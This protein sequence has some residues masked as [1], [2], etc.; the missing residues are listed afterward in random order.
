MYTARPN[1][2][3]IAWGLEI[4]CAM[5]F[6]GEHSLDSFLKIVVID[7]SHAREYLEEKLTGKR[8]SKDT[9]FLSLS[10]SLFLSL[11]LSL[12]LKTRTR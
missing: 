7:P 6:P 11:S 4:V 10:L 3:S 1:Y 2:N 5:I 9:E 12:S 8:R